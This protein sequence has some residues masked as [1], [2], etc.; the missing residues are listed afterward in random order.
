M[1]GQ[2]K[3]SFTTPLQ[4]RQANKLVNFDVTSSIT[5]E[6][7]TTDDIYINEE[8]TLQAIGE[9]AANSNASISQQY[10]ANRIRLF[11]R[12]YYRFS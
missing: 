6:A 5:S 12:N 11:W 3:I 10:S 4:E 2:F 9:G 8:D 7:F 1:N